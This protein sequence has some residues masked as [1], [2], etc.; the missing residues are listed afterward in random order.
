[1]VIVSPEMKIEKVNKSF[2]DTLGYRKDELIGLQM[3]QLLAND[4]SSDV[5]SVNQKQDN[6]GPNNT[7]SKHVMIR[8]DNTRIQVIL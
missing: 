6:E 2:C 7:N 8:R 1:M 3:E 4:E 5:F